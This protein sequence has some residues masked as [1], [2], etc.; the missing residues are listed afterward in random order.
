M[1]ILDIHN[2]SLSYPESCM[3]TV[4]IN[5]TLARTRAGDFKGSHLLNSGLSNLSKEPHI[6]KGARLKQQGT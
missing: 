2:F 3:I 6:E 1:V 5:V 4:V